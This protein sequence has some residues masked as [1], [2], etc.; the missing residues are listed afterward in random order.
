MIVQ[1]DDLRSIF[2]VTDLG[3]PSKIV[4]IEISQ[5][6]TSLTISQPLYVDS[7]LKK[8]KMIDANPVSMPLDPNIKLKPNDDGCKPNHS[9]DYTLL[10]GSLQ[11]LAIAMR[12]D[13]AYAINW[14][15]VYTTN[16]SFEHYGAA[17]RLLRYVK[18]T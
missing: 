16:L 11:Y 18:G 10:L 5:T 13:I 12:P 9:N 7:I 6:S 8:F 15:A 3:E 2:D 14:L 4:G 1:R 17:K